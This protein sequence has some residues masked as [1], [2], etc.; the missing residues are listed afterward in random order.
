[1]KKK[2]MLI[3]YLFLVMDRI[4]EIGYSGT[5]LE[6]AEILVF[7]GK[8]NKTFLHFLSNFWHIWCCAFG[9][10]YSGKSS[11]MPKIW[12]K[13]WRKALFKMPKTH[14]STTLSKPET[15]D[16][17]TR[18]SVTSTCIN[19]SYCTFAL[20]SIFRVLWSFRVYWL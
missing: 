8:L 7:K 12:Q 18:L 6:S 5:Y 4:P 13:K 1:M 17:I 10:L 9:A 19:V 3:T 2:N 20:F 16:P 14:F 11:N 15:Q